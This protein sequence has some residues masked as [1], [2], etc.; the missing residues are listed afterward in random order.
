MRTLLNSVLRISFI[1]LFYFFGIIFLFTQNLSA[2]EN[3]SLK[4]D[5]NLGIKKN[6]V[7]VDFSWSFVPYSIHYS[8]IIYHKDKFKLSASVGFSYLNRR[9]SEPRHSGYG[10]P[11]IMSELTALFGRSTHYFEVGT[12]FYT[13][14][15][16]QFFVDDSFPNNIGEMPYWG[17]SFIPRIGYRHQKS[18]GGLFWRAAYTPRIDVVKDEIRP[19]ES[20]I[21]YPLGLSVSLGFSF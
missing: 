9:A 6:L 11:V 15:E 8:R 4:D 19:D 20:L 12:G 21:F 7:Y 18:K 13:Y 17:M 3:S 16:T 10:V 1:A 5:A 2:Q 14:N